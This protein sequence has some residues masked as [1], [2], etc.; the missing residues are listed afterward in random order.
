[1]ACLI[2]AL[3]PDDAAAYRELRVRALREHPDAF[4]RTPQEVPTVEV[5]TEH[6]RQDVGSDQDLTLGAFEGEA[7]L[8][9]AAARPESGRALL[10]RGADGPRSHVIRHLIAYGLIGVPTARTTGSGGATSR[11]A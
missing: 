5:I 6:F 10:R 9:V 1:V 2:R 11:N 4:G 3:G 7:L 8:G